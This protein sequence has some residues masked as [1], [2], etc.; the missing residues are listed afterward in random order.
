MHREGA[1]P[2]SMS[3]VDGALVILTVL[4]AG[5]VAAQA[6][7]R[8]LP[9]PFLPPFAAFQGSNISYAV[10]LSA[11]VAILALMVHVVRRVRQRRL[12]PSKRASRLLTFAGGL[13]VAVMLTRLVVGLAV[14]GAPGW[15]RSGIS[16]AFHFVL[17]MF[18]LMLAAYH[19]N[20]AGRVR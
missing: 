12:E 13:Y 5:R 4:F 16:I 6:V 8:W 3:A 2:L 10:L 17:A 15:F 11:Q 18:V 1:R 19:R 20:G 9:V 7:Q 14:P